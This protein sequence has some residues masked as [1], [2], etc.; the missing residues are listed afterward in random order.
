MS[1][2]CGLLGIFRMS[3]AGADADDKSCTVAAARPPDRCLSGSQSNVSGFVDTGQEL[4]VQL[5]SKTSRRVD[6]CSVSSNASRP[7]LN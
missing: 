4:L 1:L 6:L 2:C 7:T 5:S 3:T